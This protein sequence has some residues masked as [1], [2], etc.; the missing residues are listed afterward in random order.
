MP[1]YVCCSYIY[2]EATIHSQKLLPT[3]LHIYSCGVSFSKRAYI[4]FTFLLHYT[5][6]LSFEAI[7][8]ET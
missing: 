1:Y 7:I 2:S 6:Y 8:T 5:Y 3:S 4:L